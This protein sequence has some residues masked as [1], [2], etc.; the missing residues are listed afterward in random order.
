MICR[1]LL[2]WIASSI[3]T[4]AVSGCVGVNPDASR[5]ARQHP[6]QSTSI[7]VTA[8]DSPLQAEQHPA[9]PKVRSRLAAS[10]A[11]L[12]EHAPRALA[13]TD[14]SDPTA[15][16]ATWREEAALHSSQ[17]G[18]RPRGNDDFSRLPP[19]SLARPDLAEPEPPPQMSPDAVAPN[20]GLAAPPIREMDLTTALTIADGQSTR[21]G[22]A[23]ARYREAYARLSAS[24]VLWLPSLRAGASYNHHDGRLQNIEGDVF[25]VSRSALNGGLGANAVAAGSPAVPGVLANFHTADAIFQPRIAEYAAS[26]RYA[27]TRAE[28][29]DALLDVAVAY[30]NLL[31]AVQQLRIAEA[32]RDRAQQLAELTASFAQTGAGTQADADRARTELAL[33]Q[34]EVARAEEASIVASA[35]LAEL[36]HLDPSQPIVPLEPSIVPIE[37]AQPDAPLNEL[38]AAGLSNRPE[39]AEARYLVCEA[40]Q[41][42][43]RERYAPFVPSVLL[44]ISHTGF[45][46][47]TGSELNDFGDRFDLDAVAWW[48]IR[49]LGLGERAQRSIAATRQQQAS[50]QHVQTMDRVAR[51]V[52]EAHA[53]V[54]SRRRQIAVAESSIT[55]AADSYRRNVERIREGQG[56]PIEALQ[57]LQALDAA[58]REYLRAVID[59]N[60]AQFRLQRALGWP[61]Q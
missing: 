46:G 57:S 11:R 22:L 30:L 8:A 28:T 58:N 38:L 50:W 20:A 47:G 35:R 56:L 1:R 49:N 7:E 4:A 19:A 23:A 55:A 43:Q 15:G 31:R 59:Y 2:N 10:S 26:A 34:N 51:E 9:G 32:T 12:D 44:G 60:E 6:P 5:L 27:A 48:E 3:V 16:L 40:V 52:I 36:L 24:R 18:R 41:R 21:I 45:G 37:L 14:S 33:R 13:L 25:D 53:Q 42:Y 61:I 39:L 17:S 54:T 29:N